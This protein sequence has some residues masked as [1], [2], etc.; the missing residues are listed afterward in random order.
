MSNVTRRQVATGAAWAVPVLAVGAAAPAMA[1]SPNCPVLSVSSATAIRGGVTLVLSVANPNPAYS[2]TSL[3]TVP[4]SYR[5]LNLEPDPEPAWAARPSPSTAR[6]PTWATTT[7]ALHRQLHGER[8]QRRPVRGVAVVHQRP[9]TQAPPEPTSRRSCRTE[10]PSTPRARSQQTSGEPLQSVVSHRCD[11]RVLDLGV[12]RRQRLQRPGQGLG[13]R[14]R[15]ARPGRSPPA[16]DVRRRRRPRRPCRPAGRRAARAA[17]RSRHPAGTPG[18]RP[19]R[20]RG[21]AW[22]D[23]DLSG[24]RAARGGHS[25]SRPATTSD[26]LRANGSRGPTPRPRPGAPQGRRRPG[27]RRP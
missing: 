25:V 1:A 9:L 2:I 26:S 21:P 5:I 17:G 6:A 3:T 16:G 20:P 8:P 19:R 12:A 4:G 7:R 10:S 11:S 14:A 22:G 13:R 15:A 23:G 18:V 27:T 24:R